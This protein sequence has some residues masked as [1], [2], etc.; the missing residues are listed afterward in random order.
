MMRVMPPHRSA[1][2]LLLPLAVVSAFVVACDRAP[3]PR[4]QPTSSPA[5]TATV[6]A[7]TPAPSTPSASSAAGTATQRTSVTPGTSTPRVGIKPLDPFVNRDGA[8]HYSG[9]SIEL[10]DEVARRNGWATSYQWYDTL[11][12]LLDDVTASKIDVAIAGISITREREARLDF[13]YPMFNAGLQVLA[14][15]RSDQSLLDRLGTF[16]SPTLG[17]YLVGLIAVMFLAGNVVWL[18]QRQHRYFAGVGHGMFKA[19]AIGL[20]GEPEH[21]ISRAVSVVW[22]VL[23]ICFVSMFTATLTTEL[24]VQQITGNIR[25]VS[26]LVGKQVVTVKG[27]TAAAYLT[28]R[29]IDFDGVDTVEEAFARLDGAEADAMVF[30]AP[31][32]Q[33][34]VQVTGSDRLAL[35]G[36]VFQREDYGI[37]LPA[38]S[39]LRKSIN[40]TLLEMRADGSY[41]RLYEHYFG[42]VR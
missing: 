22:I 16:V 2:R 37:A 25:G 31:V 4:P 10:W 41:D 26:D 21:P 5:A 1:M 20:V 7:S 30:D 6:V 33:H 18:F 17:L 9:F 38:G 8:A 34:H 42:R 32:L 12:A 29:R 35:V 36:N 24:T 39:A 11:P 23:G 13:T 19:A 15:Q 14:A 40:A 3:A 27:S 28:E